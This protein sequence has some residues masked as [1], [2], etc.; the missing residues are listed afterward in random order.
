MRMTPSGEMLPK[1]T[2]MTGLPTT[3]SNEHLM[4]LGTAAVHASRLEFSVAELVAELL[5]P[6]PEVGFA[7]TAGMPFQRLLALANE[8]VDERLTD[9]KYG[10]RFKD[11]RK[12]AQ[13]AMESRNELMHGHWVVSWNQETLTIQ[14]DLA[15]RRGRVKVRPNVEAPDVATVA[16]DLNVANMQVE[17][18]HANVL[19]PLGRLVEFEP[20]KYRRVSEL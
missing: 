4:E 14:D 17:L 11:I 2:I 10:V 18:F 5:D 9:A 7:V 19:L 20:G 1:T 8:L 12:F 16:G 6:K 3:L 15:T 13:S